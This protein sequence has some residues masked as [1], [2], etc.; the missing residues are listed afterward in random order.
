MQRSHGVLL[1]VAVLALMPG[2]ANAQLPTGNGRI[3]FSWDTCDPIVTNKVGAQQP[4]TLYASVLGQDEPHSA[5]QVA[6]LIGNRIPSVG[7]PCCNIGDVS[8]AWRFDVPTGGCNVGFVTMSQSP[9]PALAVSCPP[10]VPP[11]NQQH[12]TSVAHFTPP[13][14]GF[15]TNSMYLL[16][17]LIYPGGALAD[18]LTRYHLVSFTFDHMHSNFGPTPK[19][20][21]SCGGLDCRQFIFALPQRCSWLSLDGMTEKYFAP[22]SAFPVAAFNVEN[23]MGCDFVIPAGASTWGSIKAQYK[24]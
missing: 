17:A 14:L 22:P 11:L 23:D 12:P 1:A 6:I 24:R 21:T 7:D 8:D 15:N 19:D 13:G 3:Q 2:F 16:F 5:Y 10:F 4:A 9:P 18:P 20:G